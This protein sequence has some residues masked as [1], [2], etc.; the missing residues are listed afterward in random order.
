MDVVPLVTT[1]D[2]LKFYFNDRQN[3]ILTMLLVYGNSSH[4]DLGFLQYVCD[5]ITNG[6]SF[7]VFLMEH[8]FGK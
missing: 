2:A 5:E 7:L 8:H 4:F 6:P 3:G 1:L